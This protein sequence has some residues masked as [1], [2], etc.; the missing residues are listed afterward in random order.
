MSACDAGGYFTA[1][2]VVAAL[3]NEGNDSS[4]RRSAMQQYRFHRLWGGPRS[5]AR[6]ASARG[7]AA[8]QRLAPLAGSS[9][10]GRSRARRSADLLF[11]IVRHE[12]SLLS[13]SCGT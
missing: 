1:A 6:P 9:V 7:L 5:P 13:E 4:A 12:R 8:A 11:D 2:P 10:L 3:R